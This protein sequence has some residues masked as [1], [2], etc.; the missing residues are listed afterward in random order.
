MKNLDEASKQK[1]IAEIEHDFQLGLEGIAKLPIEAKFG[2][3]TAYKYYSKLLHKLKRTP[4]VKIKNT[5]I[6]IPNYQKMALL[7]KSYV[8]YQLNLI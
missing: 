6:R 1:I 3:F 4:S 8:N 7:A 5:R 2:V